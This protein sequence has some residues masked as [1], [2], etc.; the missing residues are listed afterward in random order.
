MKRWI[1]KRFSNSTE[2][3]SKHTRR[4]GSHISKSWRLLE[5]S[6]KMLTRSNGSSKKEMRSDLKWNKP[7][8]TARTL[9]AKKEVL[10]KKWKMVEINWKSNKAPTSKEFSNFWSPPILLSNTFIIRRENHL[11][12]SS[13]TTLVVL[14]HQRYLEGSR[15]WHWSQSLR[16]NKW[17]VRWPLRRRSNQMFWEQ[18]TC[19]TTR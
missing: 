2:I 19:P 18:S 15:R 8:I 10:S 9:L 13:S 14:D 12:R 1:F 7:L 6:K 3:E 16:L 5:S 4:I 11:R 17:E